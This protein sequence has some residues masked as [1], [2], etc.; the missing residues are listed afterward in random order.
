[1]ELKRTPK[2]FAIIALNLI[3]VAG[4][5]VWSLRDGLMQDQTGLLI[6][7]IVL[8]LW[9]IFLAVNL[10]RRTW[11]IRI[12]A[13]G[14]R[15]R[16]VTRDVFVPFDDMVWYVIDESRRAGVIAYDHGGAERFGAFSRGSIGAEG[17]I[18]LRKAVQDA[19]P[20][21]PDHNPRV[22]NA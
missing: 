10:I 21:L 17:M 13:G 18:T 3:V 4:C 19:R 14:V 15:I 11:Y 1:M 8:V 9:S 2:Q 20:D 16:Y 7:G 5:A 22:S 12:E 6:F